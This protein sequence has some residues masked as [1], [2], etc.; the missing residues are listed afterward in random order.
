[1]A[2]KD[3]IKVSGKVV[4]KANEAFYKEHGYTIEEPTDEEIKAEFPEYQFEAVEEQEEPAAAETA[5]APAAEA[6][7]EEPAVEAPAK[8]KYTR[9]TK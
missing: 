6:P 7:A 8:R 5:E 9:K 1:M 3:F 4:M 2:K